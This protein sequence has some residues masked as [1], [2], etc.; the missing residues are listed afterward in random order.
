MWSAIKIVLLVVLLLAG[1]I[2]ALSEWG[3]VVVLRPLGDEPGSGTRLWV[4]DLDGGPWLRASEGKA[5]AE[6]AVMAG[7][8]ELR[9]G[10]TWKRYRVYDVP[11]PLARNQVNAAMREKYGFSDRFI[12]WTEDFGQARPIRLE[13][14][15]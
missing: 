6:A 5:W 1:L 14:V 4:V 2:L 13:P 8:A 15:P 3:E 9:R 12:G 7:Q 11:G 10:G